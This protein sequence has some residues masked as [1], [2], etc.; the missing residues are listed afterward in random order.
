MDK[1]IGELATAEIN[2]V[3]DNIIS[4]DL[5]S[6]P[7]PA[8]NSFAPFYRIDERAPKIFSR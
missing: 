4:G 5:E 6:T 2:P 7:F 8:R 1:D 3:Q